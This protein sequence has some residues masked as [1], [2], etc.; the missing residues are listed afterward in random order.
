MHRRIVLGSVVLLIFLVAEG[1]VRMAAEQNSSPDLGRFLNCRAIFIVRHA[2]KQGGIDP[3][4]TEAGK[5]R[6]VRL[7]ERLANEGI[8]KIFV[9]DLRRTQQTAKPLYEFLGPQKCQ[10]FSKIRYVWD[11]IEAFKFIESKLDPEDA[12]LI[13]YHSNRIPGLL[14]LLGHTNQTVGDRFDHLFI[15]KPDQARKSL[16][17]REESYGND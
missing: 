10:I 8:T 15:L 17:L 2:E 6:A 9:T 16:E 13:V 7:K 12:I 5:K 11:P 4:L 3:E 1:C 14:D